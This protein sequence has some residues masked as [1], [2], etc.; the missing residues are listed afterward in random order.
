MKVTIKFRLI[1]TMALLGLLIVVAGVS[2]LY[3]MQK[4]NLSLQDANDN[5]MPSAVAIGE[6]QLA[7]AR[8][9]LALDRVTMH[10]E[11]P[12]SGKTLARAES[13]MATSDKA[14]ARYLTLPQG[15]EEKRLSDQMDKDRKAFIEQ[16][17]QPLVRALNAKDAEQADKITMS[18]MQPLFAK[19]SESAQAL[20]EFQTKSNARQYEDSQA[21][22]ASQ[23]W[24]TVG[25]IGA[26]VVLMLVAAASLLRSILVPIRASVTHFSRMAEG[27]L[28]NQIEV[29]GNDEMAELMQAL[30]TMQ[31]KLA[32]TVMTVRAGA[33]NIATATSEIATGNLDLSGRTE[34]QAA[35]LEETASSLE[36]LT[37]TVRQNSE[38]ARQSNQLAQDASRVAARGG[39]VVGNVINTMEAIRAAS[40]RIADIIGVIDGIA[41]QTNILALNAAVEAARAGEQGRGFAVVAS[42]VRSLAHRSAE[43]AKDIKALISDSVTQV[44]GGVTQVREAGDT[45][46]EIVA[47]IERVTA[48]MVEISAAGQEQEIGIS[49]INQAVATLDATTQQN[50]AL[51][52]EAAAAS[53]SLSEQAERLSQ[54]VAAFKLDGSS[55]PRSAGPRGGNAPRM[56]SRALL[57]HA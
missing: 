48:I 55:Q 8:S 54:A 20:S 29:R 18:V 15:D 52:E 51:V 39:E 41:F 6:S 49:Q 53:A 27:D 34:E 57:A 21:R 46:G 31:S 50:A 19:L 5:T 44:D 11:L 16:G 9:R 7:M 33:A 42:E 10:P 30:A 56:A 24:L 17:Y 35:S 38:N 2:G 25:V 45:M 43:A 47:S 26:G 14:W 28:S 4:V 22:Y 37:A 1:A 3:G 40:T 36:E 12:D 32:A 23:R 13:F